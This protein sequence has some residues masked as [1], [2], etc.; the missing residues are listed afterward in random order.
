MSLE[1]AQQVLNQAI[2]TGRSEFDKKFRLPNSLSRAVSDHA[3]RHSEN[4]L[5]SFRD[6]I[7]KSVKEAMTD[8]DLSNGGLNEVCAVIDQSIEKS[9]HRFLRAFARFPTYNPNEKWEE[10][11]SW[12]VEFR[13]GVRSEIM[14][15]IEEETEDVDDIDYVVET[16]PVD[17]REITAG[18]FEKHGFSDEVNDLMHDLVLAVTAGEIE[19]VETAMDL[20]LTKF[21]DEA[22]RELRNILDKK[23]AELRARQLELDELKMKETDL[24]ERG[25]GGLS[26]I[27]ATYEMQNN[28]TMVEYEKKLAEVVKRV[29]ELEMLLHFSENAREKLQGR[30]REHFENARETAHINRVILSELETANEVADRRLESIV[31]LQQKLAAALEREE[32]LI[33]AV[34]RLRKTRRKRRKDLL[35]CVN[36]PVCTKGIVE[37]S[38]DG[39][40]DYEKD[41]DEVVLDTIYFDSDDVEDSPES[42][43]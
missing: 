36:T 22:K 14:G 18:M 13:A 33:E 8:I 27:V 4:D 3:F 25:K 30:A 29:E 42:D 1:A 11:L 17:N 34:R 15:V 12:M 20:F 35:H 16:S 26:A 28:L 24:K 9:Q 2:R 43:D 37:G 5:E 6:V 31:N 39:A 32:Q 21:S 40:E 41:E 38:C 23:K 10:F 7:V 19:D